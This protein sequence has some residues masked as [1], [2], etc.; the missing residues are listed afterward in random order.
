MGYASRSLMSQ[1]Q[2]SAL[3]AR[4]PRRMASLRRPARRAGRPS[5][6]AR[7]RS[8][9]AA[10]SSRPPKRAWQIASRSSAASSGSSTTQA[11]GSGLSE[12][13]FEARM[14][15]GEGGAD[16]PAYPEPALDGRRVRAAVLADDQRQFEMD[17]EGQAELDVEAASEDDLTVVQDAL[18]ELERLE[19]E[20][21]GASEPAEKTVAR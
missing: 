11:R 16:V 13:D 14:G 8:L 4:S 17:F 5:V 15:I 19:G 3:K 1:F 20:I 10:R 9:S 12:R 6:R 2:R 18:G 7:M 21:A